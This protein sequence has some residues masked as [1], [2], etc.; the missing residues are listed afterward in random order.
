MVDLVTSRR[1]QWQRLRAAAL[2]P[3]TTSSLV[4][5]QSPKGEQEGEEGEGEMNG[6]CMR[7]M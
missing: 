5:C 6:K 3:P 2:N 1:Q 7:Y 4:L